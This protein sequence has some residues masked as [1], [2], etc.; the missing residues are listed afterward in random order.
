MPVHETWAWSEGEILALTQVSPMHETHLD[1]IDLGSATSHANVG[2]RV[3]IRVSRA[4]AGRELL[5]GQVRKTST[6]VLRARVESSSGS[7]T[8]HVSLVGQSADIA[9]GVGAGR[10]RVSSS[11]LTIPALRSLGP[12]SICSSSVTST[13]EIAH[14]PCTWEGLRVSKRKLGAGRPRLTWPISG[15]VVASGQLNPYFNVA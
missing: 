15:D 6:V 9:R 2:S 10:G 14:R 12:N 8:G 3:H 4:G 5:T 13:A 11:P 7:S 1:D